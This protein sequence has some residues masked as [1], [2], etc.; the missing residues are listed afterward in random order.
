MIN[1]CRICLIGGAAGLSLF[2]QTPHQPIFISPTQ[3]NVASLLPNPPA[4]DSKEGKAELA[5][6]H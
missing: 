1:F 4:D 3:L 5:E 2:A 6:I